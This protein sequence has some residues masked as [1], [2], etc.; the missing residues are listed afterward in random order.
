MGRVGVNDPCDR[1][2]NFHRLGAEVLQRVI[3]CGAVEGCGDGS[4][5]LRLD[6]C[7]IAR[8]LEGGVTAQ[9][10]PGQNGRRM[11]LGHESFRL[12]GNRAKDHH[13]GYREGRE[14]DQKCWLVAIEVQHLPHPNQES[15]GGSEAP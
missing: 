5:I 7:T 2:G 4:Q 8:Q 14:Q 9:A 12:R 1:R 10:C 13:S 3:V 6:A 15:Q 11:V